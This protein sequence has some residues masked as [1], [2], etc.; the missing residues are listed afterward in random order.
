M[1]PIGYVRRAHGIQGAMVVRPLSDVAHQ[2]YVPGAVLKTDED[3]ERSLEVLVV[4]PHKDG[5]LVTVEGVMTRNQ[6]EAMRGVTFL[7]PAE[8]RRRL[9]DDEYWEDDLVGLQAEDASGRALGT[10]A[11]VV[12][13]AA[14]DRIAIATADGTNVEVPFVAAIVIDVNVADGKVVL[15]PPLG[16]L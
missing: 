5:L 16:L 12:F 3:P 11:G 7:I 1:I 15:D 2:R 14:Q 9:G 8:D 6:A 13:G 4:R 10:V